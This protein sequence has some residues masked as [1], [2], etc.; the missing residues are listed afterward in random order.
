M[1]KKYLKDFLILSISF[2]MAL[3]YLYYLKPLVDDEIYNYG[4]AN[5]IINGLIPYKDF[6]MIILPLYPYLLALFLIIVGNRLIVYHISL[7]LIIAFITWY[8]SKKIKYNSI[9]IFLLLLVYPYTGYNMFCLLLLF[10]L[11][12]IKDKNK[13]VIEAIIISMMFLTKQTLILLIIPSIINSKKKFKT[14]SVYLISFFLLL[15]YLIINNNLHQF[16]D[17]CF[18]GMFDFTAN[19]NTGTKGFLFFELLIIIYLI[20]IIIKEKRKDLLYLLLFQIIV[21]PIVDYFH[22]II[23]FIP[24]VY[25]LLDRYN[26]NFIFKLFT[27]ASVITFFILLNSSTIKDR[28]ILYHYNIKNYMYHRY[29]LNITNDYL[30]NIDD[31][32]KKYSDYKL[33]ILS[34]YAYIIKLNLDLPIN[35]YD[36]INR[37]NMGYK[38]EDKYIK[39]I[40]EYCQNN[41]CLFIVNENEIAPEARTQTSEKIIK[42]II[43]EYRRIQSSNTFNIYIN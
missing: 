36:I 23:G 12:I 20:Y 24:V 7:S 41:K 26:K 38:G 32:S 19:N 8:S 22:F 42:Y 16:L 6:N 17:Y 2:L 18:F 21:F 43:K 9:I 33:Y 30:K 3:I 31:Y 27:F 14:I 25:C 10:I 39:E 37:G 11:F 35:K 4:F 5:N 29:T 13:E 15:L 34:N 40:D 28:N 1:Y